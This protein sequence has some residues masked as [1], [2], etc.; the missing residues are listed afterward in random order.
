MIPFSESLVRGAIGKLFVIKHYKRG[1]IIKTKYPNMQG[2]VPSSKQKISRRTFRKAV[3]FAQA[4]YWNK[5]KKETWYRQLRKPRRLF[6]A[7][8]KVYYKQKAERTFR[9]NQRLNKWRRTL[10]T[11]GGVPATLTHTHL[12][13]SSL[14]LTLFAAYSLQLRPHHSP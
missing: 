1:R 14:L 11:N 12:C 10:Q 5:E 2:I 7:L 6:Q 13:N 9:N 3:Q 8:M 4:I